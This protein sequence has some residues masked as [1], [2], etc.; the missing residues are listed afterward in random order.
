MVTEQN[1]HLVPH[2][3]SR[4]FKHANLAVTRA[5]VQIQCYQN[6]RFLNATAIPGLLIIPGL[7][8]EKKRGFREVENSLKK[9]VSGS[10]KPMLETLRPALLWCVVGAGLPDWPFCGQISN[11]AVFQ[12]D[13]PYDFWVGRLAFF[14]R[15]LKVV[16]PK[17]FSVDR[18]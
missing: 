2:D 11:L 3:N 15:F 4:K 13:W 8:V 1:P 17:I 18:F 16:W 10:G 12:V 14:G 6:H 9:R 5:N 7:V